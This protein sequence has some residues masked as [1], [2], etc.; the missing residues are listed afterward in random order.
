MVKRSH[1]TRNKSRTIMKKG[2]REKMP[3]AS[4][5]LRTFSDGE[6][7]VIRIDSA[8]TKGRPSKRFRGKVG[9]IVGMQGK[10]YKLKIKDGQKEKQIIVNPVHIKPLR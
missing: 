10:C 9:E 3:T 8:V 7:A 4:R 2:I 5:V 1:G 6:K